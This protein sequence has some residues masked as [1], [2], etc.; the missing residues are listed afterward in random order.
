[1]RWQKCNLSS[2]SSEVSCFTIDRFTAIYR[3]AEHDWQKEKKEKRKEKFPKRFKIR[4]H[5]SCLK[6]SIT[7]EFVSLKKHKWR[8]SVWY[9][10]IYPFPMPKNTFCVSSISGFSDKYSNYCMEDR[11]A[12]RKRKWGICWLLNWKF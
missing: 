8:I 2:F 7:N 4:V 11:K 3:D 9:T 10:L 5:T 6:A 1:M 12:V